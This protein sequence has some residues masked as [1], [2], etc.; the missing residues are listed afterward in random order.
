MAE[1]ELPIDASEKNY[2]VSTTLE[3]VT[4]TF[5]VRWNGRAGSWF[6]DLYDVDG[7]IIMAGIRILTG[8]NLGR[9]C[10]DPRKP[11]GAIVAS[12]L[13]GAGRE[14]TRDDLGTRVKLYYI[15]VADLLAG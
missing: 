3:G 15:P 13:S 9:R 10:T 2:S 12:D 14:A 11:P 7:N 1:S 6:F 4:Y 5:V 8:A